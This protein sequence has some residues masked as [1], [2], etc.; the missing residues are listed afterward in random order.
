LA[1]V[2]GARSFSSSSTIRPMLVVSAT[3]TVAGAGVDGVGVGVGVATWAARRQA[4]ARIIAA[5]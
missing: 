1:V 4:R 5:P 2:I 3:R